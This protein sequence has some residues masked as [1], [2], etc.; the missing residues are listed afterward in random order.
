[1]LDTKT[2]TATNPKPKR[3]ANRAAPTLRDLQ[4]AFQKAVIEGDDAILGLI[5]PNSRT[6]NQVLLGVYRHAYVGRLADIVGS[7]F[8]HVRSYV[9]ADAFAAVARDYVR[10]F[11][12][13]T[14]NARWFSHRFP[15]FLATSPLYQSRTELADLALI[16]RALGDAFDAR[17]T[18]AETLDRLRTVPSERWAELTFTPH[19]STHRLNLLSNA[20][21]LWS[22]LKAGDV[23]PL[24]E[25]AETPERLIV[26][27]QDLT[28]KIRALEP[29]EAMMWDE[30][31]KGVPF[32]ALC[33][34]VTVFG[35]P[36]TAA[37]R[38]AQY[39]QG[40]LTTGLLARA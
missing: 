11:P 17:D 34:L 3:P 38:A 32:G 13:R 15:E 40:W 20:L 33:E 9:G 23:P 14:P 8:E 6:N 24:V 35:E 37:L 26:W 27:R 36:D 1:M 12:S 2:K 4:D 28:S 7:D 30:A 21:A 25:I 31:A 18:E 22:A 19:P 5:P 16:E 29:E 39:L 10:V